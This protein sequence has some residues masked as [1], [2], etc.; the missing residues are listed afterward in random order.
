ME[1]KPVS[2]KENNDH[3]GLV[4]SGLREE[5]KNIDAKIKKARG[6][7]FNFMGPILSSKSLL[8]PNLLMHVFRTY[9]CPIAR[10]GLS[11]MTL[12]ENHLEPLAIFQRKILRSFLRLSEQSP[13]PALHF[14]TGELTIVAKVHRDVFGLFYNVWI[15]PQ[16]KV[17]DIVKYLLENAPNNSNT[18]STHLKNLAKMY[19]IEDPLLMITGHPP[20]KDNFKRYICAKITSYCEK[21]LRNAAQTN[22]KMEFLNVSVKGLNGRVHPALDGAHSTKD[23]PKLRAHVKLLCGD[24]ITYERRA[25]YCGSSPHCR[26]CC[27]DQSPE[28]RPKEDICHIL[29]QCPS[30]KETRDR[31][32]SEINDI[33]R[34]SAYNLSCIFSSDKLLTQFILDCTSLNLPVRISPEDPLCGTVFTLSRDLSYSICSQRSRMLKQLMESR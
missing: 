30:F 32:V 14:L 5:E 19:D 29:A 2:V 9:I 24:L 1:G 20:P 28:S 17:Y 26:L 7:L 33:C 34:Q 21:T 11:A 23:I 15:N 3:L 25:K 16:T 22:S 10:S 13:I 18:W 4:V 6:S 8:S 31:I 12:R 27:Q